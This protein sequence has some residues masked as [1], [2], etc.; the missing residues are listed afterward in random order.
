MGLYQGGRPSLQP[1]GC[2]RRFRPICRALAPVRDA[3][4]RS[5]R[6]CGPQRRLWRILVSGLLTLLR[7]LR[8][9]PSAFDLADSR[10]PLSQ[11]LDT[12]GIAW[13]VSA[14][15][16]GEENLTTTWRRAPAPMLSSIRDTMSALLPQCQQPT[17]SPPSG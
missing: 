8:F 5:G 13:A 7:R 14:F 3:G 10:A 2:R 11:S 17:A 4:R 9:F 15:A 12:T 6:L 16:I 1:P